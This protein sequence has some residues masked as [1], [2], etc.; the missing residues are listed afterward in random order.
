MAPPGVRRGKA[1][2]R[3]DPADQPGPALSDNLQALAA[4]Y[5]GHHHPS[6]PVLTGPQT[7]GQGSGSGSGPGLAH[8][9]GKME[10]P[11]SE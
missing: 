2:T 11:W 5:S 10:I 1:T 8:M 6:R 3:I 4:W 9:R 7:G